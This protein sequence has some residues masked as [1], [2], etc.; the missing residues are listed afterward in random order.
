MKLINEGKK[1][2][3]HPLTF[4]KNATLTTTIANIISKNAKNAK[5]KKKINSHGSLIKIY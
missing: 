3:M 5:K 2:T 1:M 4:F